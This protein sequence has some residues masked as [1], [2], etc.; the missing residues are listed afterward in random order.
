LTAKRQLSPFSQAIIEVVVPT[1]FVTPKITFTG[2]EDPKSLP[3]PDVDLGGHE[4]HAL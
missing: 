1:N 2:T 3:S 4:R